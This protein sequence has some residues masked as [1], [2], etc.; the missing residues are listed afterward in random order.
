MGFT[1]DEVRCHDLDIEACLPGRAECIDEA[2][3]TVGELLRQVNGLIRGA[4]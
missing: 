4:A 2:K 1:C 3:A